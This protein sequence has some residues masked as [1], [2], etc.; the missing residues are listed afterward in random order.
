LDEPFD[1]IGEWHVDTTSEQPIDDLAT[2][3][4]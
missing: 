2:N 1:T 4:E 3:V